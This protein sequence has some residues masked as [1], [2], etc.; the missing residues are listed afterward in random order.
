MLWLFAALSST[1][2]GVL[3]GAVAKDFLESISPRYQNSSAFVTVGV[4]AVCLA[5]LVWAAYFEG[6]RNEEKDKRK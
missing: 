3:V 5:A 6:D 4:G 1:A 2:F